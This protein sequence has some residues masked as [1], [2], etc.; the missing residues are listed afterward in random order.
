MEKTLEIAQGHLLGG[1][2]DHV[3]N[4]TQVIVKNIWIRGDFAS[5]SEYLDNVT[6]GGH[7][8]G[9]MNGIGDDGTWDIGTLMMEVLVKAPVMVALLLYMAKTVIIQL[10]VGHMT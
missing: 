4:A 1:I 5:S 9:R 10:E 6:I 7:N 2:K 8:F 3:G